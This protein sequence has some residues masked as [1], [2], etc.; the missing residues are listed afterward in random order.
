MAKKD[1]VRTS[2]V[3]TKYVK[4]INTYDTGKYTVF[5][6][7]DESGNLAIHYQLRPEL[8]TDKKAATMAKLFLTKMSKVQLGDICLACCRCREIHEDGFNQSVYYL[9]VETIAYALCRYEIEQ[10]YYNGILQDFAVEKHIRDWSEIE[11]GKEK[12]PREWC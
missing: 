8:I 2:D 7:E 6:F 1:E 11:A 10:R 5:E 4:Y 12:R 3:F 9:N